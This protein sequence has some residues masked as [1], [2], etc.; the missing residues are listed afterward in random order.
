MNTIVVGKPI[1]PGVTLHHQIHQRAVTT[2]VNRS[3]LKLRKT[4]VHSNRNSEY[5]Q[6]SEFNNINADLNTDLFLRY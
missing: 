4:S 1:S 2:D 3:R 5:H 6:F